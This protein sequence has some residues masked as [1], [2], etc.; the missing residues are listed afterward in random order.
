MPIDE[1]EYS[2]DDLGYHYNE[3]E[4]CNSICSDEED[5]Q[6]AAYPQGNADA[7]VQ[8]VRLDV[9]MEFESMALFKKVVRKYNITIGRSIFFPRV[10][11]KRSKA[12]C[13]YENC[14]WKIYCARR[15]HLLSY[16]VKTFVD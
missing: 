6:P 15:T 13:Y 5:A 3:S 1:E 14:P 11:P 7:R 9:R 12:I 4:Y 8:Q 2:S 10:D 16:Q